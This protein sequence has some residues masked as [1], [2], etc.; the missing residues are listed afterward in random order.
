MKKPIVPPADNDEQAQQMGPC[1]DHNAMLTTF[2]LEYL[3]A[4]GLDTAAKEA[5]VLQ[6]MLNTA[7]FSSQTLEQKITLGDLYFYRYFYT[8]TNDGDQRSILNPSN[9]PTTPFVSDEAIATAC[10]DNTSTPPCEHQALSYN[11]IPCPKKFS[12][13]STIPKALLTK[14]EPKRSLL[15][16]KTS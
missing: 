10:A 8:K 1:C 7:N 5:E 14:W 12:T 11:G 13:T 15:S 16:S 9:W 4:L 3:G 2:V 6:D